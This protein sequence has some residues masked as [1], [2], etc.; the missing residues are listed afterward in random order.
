E[1]IKARWEIFDKHDEVLI[2][3]LHEYPDNDDDALTS[4]PIR[5]KLWDQWNGGRIW[6]EVRCQD[7]KASC[8]I[9]IDVDSYP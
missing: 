5:A 7:Q 6:R 8:M 9:L 1:P 3:E 2:G 4:W